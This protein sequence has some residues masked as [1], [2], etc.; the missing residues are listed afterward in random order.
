MVPIA[1]IA[2]STTIAPRI[3]I[4][5]RLACEAIKPGYDTSADEFGV[6]RIV[7]PPSKLCAQ[8]PD[9]QAAVAQLTTREW[10]V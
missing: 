1:A 9:V 7:E 6:T 10:S 5:T 4:F 3:E 2:T 8:D